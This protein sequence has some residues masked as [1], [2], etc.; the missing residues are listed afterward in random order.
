[1]E[2]IEGGAR[3]ADSLAHKWASRNKVPTHTFRANWEEYGKRAGFIRNQQMLDE[4][5]PNVVLAF[6]TD[7][8]N[9]SKGTLGMIKIAQKAGVEVFVFPEISGGNTPE[10]QSS[11]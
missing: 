10:E 9:K 5:K 8:H 3:G 4:G 1:M 7:I 2:L 11:F 6:F